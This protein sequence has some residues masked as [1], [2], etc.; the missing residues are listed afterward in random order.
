MFLIVFFA[1]I[2][3]P[4]A[5]ALVGG[6]RE[7][8]QAREQPEVM[9]VGSNG[10]FCT[11]AIIAQNVVL[12]AAHCLGPGFD[13]KVLDTAVGQPP[14]FHDVET[15]AIHP[16]FRLGSLLAHRA[17]A[18]VALLKL[19]IPYDRKPAQLL[20]PRDRIRVGERFIVRGYGVTKPGEAR[21]GGSLRAAALVATGQPGTLQLRLVD[22][23]RLGATAGLGAC[24]GDSGAPLYQE[25]PNGLAIVGIMSW[26]TG[27]NG[28]SG[29]GGLTGATPLAAYQ[30]W[31][32]TTAAK[33]RR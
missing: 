2:F 6:A 25:T 11:G 28:Q 14:I 31:I 9:V 17:T 27:P 12:T 10:S 18:D 5:H 3:V 26:S 16:Q 29:C 21:T 22:A 15:V 32:E 23:S 13:Y 19:R 1:L 24:T 33:L 7:V 30:A 8:P 4:P 20:P